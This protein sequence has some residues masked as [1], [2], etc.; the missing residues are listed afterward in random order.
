VT[1]RLPA[2][3]ARS[4]FVYLVLHRDWPTSRPDLVDAL[5]PAEPPPAAE[6]ALAALLSRVRAAVGPEV[7]PVSTDI[8]LLLPGSAQV[9]LEIAEISAHRAEVAVATKDWATAWTCSRIAINTARRG[10]LPDTRTP[11]ADGQRARLRDVRLRGY[12]AS[13]EAALALGGSEIAGAERAAAAI[14]AEEPLRESGYRLAMRACVARG[15]AAEALRIYGQMRRR[16]ADELGVDPG[17]ESRALF[18]DVLSTSSTSSTSSI[19][20]ATTG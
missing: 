14:I 12:E 16:I 4:L 3:Q 20:P 19:A 18:E 17:P 5:W 7:L 6:R 15:N 1:D 13:G 10:F 2:G 11:W 9:D 8:R